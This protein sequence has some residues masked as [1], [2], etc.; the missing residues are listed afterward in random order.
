MGTYCSILFD[1]EDVCAR[2]SVIPDEYCALFQESDRR[3]NLTTRS[4]S[5]EEFEL[6]YEAPRDVVLGRLAL[7]GCTEEVVRFRF[8]Q[9]RKG[10]IE[11]LEETAYEGSTWAQ[12]EVALLS[13]LTL[14]KWQA[15]V[16]GVL[17]TRYNGSEPSNDIDKHMKED[18]DGWLWFDGYNSLTMIRALLDASPQVTTVKLELS[19]L[20][21]GGYIFHDAAVCASRRKE[22]LSRLQPLA[23]TVI[24]AEGVT[25]IRILEQSL[26]ALFP[27][28]R[29]YFSFFDYEELRVDGGAS[30]L[31]KFLK[32]FASARAPIRL[33]AVF[34]NDT[35][36]RHAYRTA[37][38]LGLPS[39]MGLVVLPDI[40]IARAYPTVGP[41]GEHLVDVNGKA[42]GIE[43]YLGREA[44]TSD[45]ALRPVRWTGYD[46]AANAYQG[47][48]DGKAQVQDAFARAIAASISPADA[49][50]KYPEQGAVWSAIFARVSEMTSEIQRA[51]PSWDSWTFTYAQMPSSEDIPSSVQ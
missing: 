10:R 32:A 1:A 7:L 43:L 21:S 15:R 29:E 40:E 9:W 5:D 39:N 48:I 4:D 45:G 12:D 31:V 50:D 13:E 38:R 34:D 16:P 41:Q 6:V 2:K 25:D 24:L 22:E 35:A 11:R 18:D 17:A 49:R 37:S 19:G 23:P 44:L 30:Y 14:E 26:K 20:A 36:G 8:E 46:R 28:R 27:E 3:S 42:A 47:E 51:L 33:V